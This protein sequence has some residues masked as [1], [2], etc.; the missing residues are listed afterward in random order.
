MYGLSSAKHRAPR[1]AL[2]SPREAANADG[3][4]AV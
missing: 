2:V 4:L 1:T 3:T